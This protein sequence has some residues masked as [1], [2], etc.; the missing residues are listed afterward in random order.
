MAETQHGEHE[1]PAEPE[2]SEG[3]VG[4]FLAVALI[5]LVFAFMIAL[6]G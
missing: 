1:P 6:V 4:I 3:V 5:V 2:V